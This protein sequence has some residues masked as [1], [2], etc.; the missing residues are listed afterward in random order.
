[1]SKKA[2]KSKEELKKPW[3]KT[4]KWSSY[5]SIFLILAATVEFWWVEYADKAINGITNEKEQ[6][7]SENKLRWEN[8]QN[9]TTVYFKTKK[10]VAK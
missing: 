9:A 7:E 4:S 5:I 2:P 10:A 1:M 8:T 3:K 6:L